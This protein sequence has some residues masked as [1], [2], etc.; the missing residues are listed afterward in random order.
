[1]SRSAGVCQPRSRAISGEMPKA[2][3]SSISGTWLVECFVVP[4]E[5]ATLKERQYLRPC[6]ARL[7]PINPDS[8]SLM[9]LYAS[10]AHACIE[11]DLQGALT[12][13]QCPVSQLASD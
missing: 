9:V 5:I 12:M 4:D 6:Q 7:D 13:V 11:H 2:M 10:N 8:V 1:M 3:S